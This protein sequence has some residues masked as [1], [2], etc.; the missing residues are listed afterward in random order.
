VIVV[1][2]VTERCNL[3]CG[4]C[5]YDRRVERPR[6][7]A[8]PG[9]VLA[10][11]AALAAYQRRTGDQVLVS[12]LGGEPLLWRPLAGLTAALTG[13]LGLRVSVTTNG[14]ALASPAV[15]A[16]LLEHYSEV[17]VSVD[18]FA[19]VHDRLRGWPGGF[20][21]LRRAVA[22]LA[23][24]KRRAGRGPLLRANVVL[25]RDN[26]ADFER[27][28]VELSGWG[29]EEITFNQLGGNDRPEFFPAHRLRPEDVDRLDRRLD[30]LRARLAPAGTALRG[31]DRYVERIASSTAGRRLPVYECA[32]GERF[33]FV[34]ERGVVAPCS[35]TGDAYGVPLS[36]LATADDVAA[37]PARFAAA[38]G[39]RRAA[40]CD[41]CP[42]T[43]VF[44]KF[45][46]VE[47][48]A[49]ES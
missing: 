13:E 14:T 8:E 6:A 30:A 39:R 15:R 27:L 1:W 46:P 43:Q 7:D 10:F 22:A 3:A 45:A 35:F 37:L 41:D 12:W 32:P 49:A 21:T 28:C 48:H 40:V 24:D 33:L 47:R 25:M 20:A 31:G 5:A 17:T 9:A 18:G 42:S 29:V 34:S 2:R 26:V 44:D 16:H 23:A 4:F 19:P 11:G 38:R 36:E